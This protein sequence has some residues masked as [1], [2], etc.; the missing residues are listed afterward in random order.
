MVYEKKMQPAPYLKRL[1]E[2]E[3]LSQRRLAELAGVSRHTINGIE[4]G[5][6]GQPGTLRKLAAVLGALPDDLTG[7]PGM[8]PEQMEAYLDLLLTEKKTIAPGDP[9]YD[10]NLMATMTDAELAQFVRKNPAARHRVA[11]LMA[12]QERLSAAIAE[13]SREHEEE[14]ARLEAENQQDAG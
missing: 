6:E 2:S 1:R 14:Q 10:N 7:K 4:A 9:L 5:R 12:H 3:R 11:A 8:P 13:A